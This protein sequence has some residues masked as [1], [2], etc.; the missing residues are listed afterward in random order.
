MS[1]GAGAQAW[2]CNVTVVGSIPTQEMKYL[3]KFMF[4]FICSG[5]EVKSDVEFLHSRSASKI[6]Q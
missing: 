2:D 1:S 3:F 5:V 6:P 4:P